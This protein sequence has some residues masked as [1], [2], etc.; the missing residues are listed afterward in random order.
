M[1]KDE[2][3]ALYLAHGFT[4]AR[5]PD[6]SMDLDPAFYSVAQA[7]AERYS[8]IYGHPVGNIE[9]AAAGGAEARTMALFHDKAASIEFPVYIMRQPAKTPALATSSKPSP[10][11]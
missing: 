4:L 1:I 8:N 7:L 5:Q 9:I 11:Y 2:I 6:G 10:E 3:R